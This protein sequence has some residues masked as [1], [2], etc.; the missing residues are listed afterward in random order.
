MTRKTLRSEDSRKWLCPWCGTIADLPTAYQVI[1]DTKTCSC[2]AI[3]LGAPPWDFD[4]IIDDAI[5]IFGVAT[6]P[7]S[8]GFDPLLLEDIRRS[9]VEV[10]EGALVEGFPG[11]VR[12]KGDIAC[13]SALSPLRITSYVPLFRSP[14]PIIQVMLLNGDADGSRPHAHAGQRDPGR[15]TS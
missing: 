9:G 13:C 1:C 3:V 6:R 10:R 2:G 4:E 8:G 14:N 7:E 5:N 12:C 11:M 15:R